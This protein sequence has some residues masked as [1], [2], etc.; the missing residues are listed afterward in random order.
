VIA[1]A[2][3]GWGTSAGAEP[4]TDTQLA[5]ADE[6][7][8][9][10]RELDVVVG[11]LASLKQRLV[12]PEQQA[13][14]E[15]IHGLGPAASKI[16]GVA[17]G[18]SIGGYAEG[19]YRR[20]IGDASGDGDDRADFLR[21]VLYVGYKFTD[22]LVFNSEIEVEHASTGESGEV[23]L[24]FATL[25][26]LWR[27]ELNVRGGLL[28]VPMGFVNEVHEPPFYL[29][30]ERPE[31][32]RRIL[33]TTWR[34]NGAGIFGSLAERVDYRVY[35]VNGFDASGFSSAGLRGGRQKGSQA[36]AEDLAFVTRADV[37][38]FGGLRVGGSYYVGNSGQDQRLPL[39]GAKLP[40]V[41]TQL[42]E[43]HG[44]W[45]RGPWWARALWAEGRLSDTAALSAR[46]SAEQGRAVRVAERMI[47]GYGELGFDLLAWLWPGS[48][49]SLMPFFRFE[50]VD[51][52]QDLS[53]ALSRDRAQPRRLFIP[54]VQWKPH[55]SV[56]LKLDYR[57]IDNWSGSA[58][59]ELSVGLG[60]VF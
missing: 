40:S 45:R 48:D 36:R 10:R 46:L 13:E 58:A 50:Y 15:S 27:P 3:A 32:E 37:D 17:Q 19:F 28:L 43:A 49:Q 18:L 7:R 52:Q 5:Q 39:T 59:D 34:E 38:L 16:Y 26:Y 21:S 6:I 57:N 4:P 9:L 23:S 20:Q 42:F 2:C 53:S 44:E 47:G 24:E 35:V 51:T 1:A 30:T 56:V 41:R 33:P 54:G 25:D 22:R 29:G 14:L 8:E 11:E 12:V 31:V 60:L 55:P